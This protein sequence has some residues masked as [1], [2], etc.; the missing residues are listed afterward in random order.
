LF[1]L[2]CGLK[3]RGSV[4]LQQTTRGSRGRSF[5]FSVSYSHPNYRVEQKL[6]HAQYVMLPLIFLAAVYFVLSSF[7][8]AVYFVLSS[9]PAAVYFVLS[10][11]LAAVYF[12]L[13]SFLAAVYFV[14]SSFLVAVYF[15][16][17]SFL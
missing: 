1:L 4:L 5:V 10:S 2:I 15:V 17:S 12:V 9:F 3:S 16:L 14:L 11:F 6:L 13:S 8:A 7:L